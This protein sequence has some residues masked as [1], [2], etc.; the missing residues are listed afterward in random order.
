MKK[1]TIYFFSLIV[2][3]QFVFANSTVAAIQL[4]PS[5]VSVRSDAIVYILLFANTIGIIILATLF[6]IVQRKYFPELLK[7]TKEEIK[8]EK[9]AHKHHYDEHIVEQLHRYIVYYQE[10]GYSHAHLRKALQE[11]GYHIHDIEE[12]ITR[13]LM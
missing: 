6:L 9:I 5:P 3:L 2:F 11:Q 7:T 8:E 4:T 12:A 10:H 1:G 13:T